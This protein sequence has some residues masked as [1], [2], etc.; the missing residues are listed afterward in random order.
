MAPE[1]NLLRRARHVHLMLCTIEEILD[2]TG[3]PTI[4]GTDLIAW[5]RRLYHDVVVEAY[6]SDIFREP[7]RQVLEY[8]IEHWELQPTL[9][10]ALMDTI[11]GLLLEC[12]QHPGALKELA[13][14]MRRTT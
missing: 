2:R 11:I 10:R 12:R 8:V 7:D 3:E 1:L 9:V 13:G 14:V 5:N 4:R 6:H